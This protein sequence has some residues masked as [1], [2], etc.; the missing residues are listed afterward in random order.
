[1]LDLKTVAQNYEQVIARLNTRGGGLDLGPLK[2]L[3]QERGSLY[4]AMEGLSHKRNLANEEI[5]KKV[6]EDPQAVDAARGEMRALA[7]EIKEKET[8]LK[9]VED[10]LARINYLIPNVPHESVPVGA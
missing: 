4:Q 10:E 3:F 5:K 7:Q 8:R 1:M 6:K 2:R 9:E